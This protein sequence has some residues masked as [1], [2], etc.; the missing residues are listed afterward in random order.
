MQDVAIG[1]ITIKDRDVSDHKLS[2][3]GVWGGC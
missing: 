2:F 1:L 3:V